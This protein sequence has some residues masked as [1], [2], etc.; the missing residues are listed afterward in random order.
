MGQYK[1][2]PLEEH[3][4]D[5]LLEVAGGHSVKTEFYVQALAMTGMRV[6]E[7][8][9]M[10]RS[11]LK[12]DHGAAEGPRDWVELR[13]PGGDDPEA[14]DCE[15]GDCRTKARWRARDALGDGASE[16]EWDA[17][18][19][20]LLDEYW[21]PKSEAGARTIAV[22]ADRQ[23]RFREV[24]WEYFDGRDGVDVRRETIWY[25]VTKL[26]DEVS[27]DTRVTSHALRHTWGTLAAKNK[28]SQYYIQESMG[29]ADI[30]SS[31]TYI[32]MSG[33]M[34]REENSDVW[35]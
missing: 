19:E 13:V 6:S 10:R 12:A 24:A 17:L 2:K 27:F 4:L 8:S 23:A 22:D 29:H 20:E 32:K 31:T 14:P 33:R 35:D 1:Q 9:H 11:W 18:T 30:A 5:E 26:D 34:V 16:E 7:L 15:C 25:H 21:K 3:E 28:A